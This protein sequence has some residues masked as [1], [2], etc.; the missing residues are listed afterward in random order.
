VER[1]GTEKER[2]KGRGQ[3]SIGVRKKEREIISSDSLWQILCS[4][5]S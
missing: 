4:C 2:R 3:Q 1:D 5:S